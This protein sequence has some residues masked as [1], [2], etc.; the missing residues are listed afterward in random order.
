VCFF[1]Y[2]QSPCVCGFVN[3]VMFPPAHNGL[4]FRKAEQD[5]TCAQDVLHTFEHGASVYSLIRRTRVS[6]KEP[7]IVGVFPRNRSNGRKSRKV[8]CLA[9]VRGTRLECIKPLCKACGCFTTTKA[10]DT[11]AFC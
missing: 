6:W 11:S 3:F 8:P 4:L 1:F 5:L 9:V 7:C 2:I 10:K